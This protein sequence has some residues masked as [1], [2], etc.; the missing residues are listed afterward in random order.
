MT[1]RYLGDEFFIT[2]S[3]IFSNFVFLEINPSEQN[4]QKT[5]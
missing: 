1:I 2:F 4:R 5:V 3:R